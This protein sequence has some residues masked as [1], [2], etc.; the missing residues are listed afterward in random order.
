MIHTPHGLLELLVAAARL[1]DASGDFD[2]LASHDDAVCDV[3][4]CLEERASAPLVEV[5]TI[6]DVT[7]RAARAVYSSGSVKGKAKR[8]LYPRNVLAK[9]RV[10]VA[11][12]QMGVEVPTSWPSWW[13]VT[14]HYAVRPDGSIARV[15]PIDVRL[16]STNRADRSPFACV[17][18][19]FAGNF[20]G[21]DGTGNWAWPDRN[22]HG[23]AGEAQL[24]SGLWLLAH[25][26]AEVEAAGGILEGVIPHRTTGRDEHGKPNRQICPGS[27]V[28]SGVG[29]RGAADLGLAIP[30]PTW[31]AGGLTIPDVWHGPDFQ[32]VTRYL[33]AA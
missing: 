26:K 25:I 16:I 4:A 18:I 29:E 2:G 10:I 15:H 27:R 22:G 33:A 13:K 32:R 28:W 23:R 8:T 14:C 1:T 21:V 12:H 11:L 19:E 24:R 7:D 30:G 17:A 3:S 20:E 5:P 6:V 9:R 31:K